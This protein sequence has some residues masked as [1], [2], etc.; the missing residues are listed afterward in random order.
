MKILDRLK[1]P[2]RKTP[3]DF[4]KRIRR[5]KNSNTNSKF[6]FTRSN[7]ADDGVL[8]SE[9]NQTITTSNGASGGGIMSKTP[10][11]TRSIMRPDEPGRGGSGGNVH[12]PTSNMDTLIAIPALESRSDDEKVD[13]A[14]EIDLGN[15]E[16]LEQPQPQQPVKADFLSNL[17][18]KLRDVKHNNKQSKPKPF[19]PTAASSPP[20]SPPQLSR[21]S[22]FMS[23]MSTSSDDRYLNIRDKAMIPGRL[24]RGGYRKLRSTSHQTPGGSSGQAKSLAKRIYHNIVGPTGNRPITE[25]DLYPFFRTHQ[26]AAEAFRIFDRDGNGDISKSELRSACVRIYRERKNLARSMRDLS[27]ATG[28]L[29]LLFL[30]VFI[31]IWVCN[32]ISHYSYH[33]GLITSS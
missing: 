3:Q 2:R 27:Q 17:T 20:E 33:S 25:M 14:T 12:F 18:K 31:V 10:P 22:T 6:V 7:S 32:N 5:N 11:M 21:N 26:E 28:K 19:D 15:K 24:I 16:T 8:S 23:W 29:D 4:L 9:G 13:P 1:K 30:V